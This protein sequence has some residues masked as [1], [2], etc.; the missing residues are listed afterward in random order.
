LAAG[1]SA[2]HVVAGVGNLLE[3]G[4]V[5]EPLI[6]TVVRLLVGAA[7]IPFSELRCAPR[8]LPC[9]WR[10]VRCGRLSRQ[11]CLGIYSCYQCPQNSVTNVPKIV[12]PM[13]PR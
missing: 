5:P 11:P 13:S 1:R 3:Y 8:A 10:S 2:A 9:D 7:D 12:L 4:R 6:P